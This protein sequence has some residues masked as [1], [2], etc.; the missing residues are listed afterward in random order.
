MKNLRTALLCAIMACSGMAA[1]AQNDNIPINEPDLNKPRLFN[2]LSERI[3]VSQAEMDNLFQINVGT[4][5]QLSLAA[6][7]SVRFEGDLIS[8]STVSQEGVQT[9]IV[10]STNFN[11]ARMT[12]TKRLNADGTVSYIGRILSFQHGDFYELTNQQGQWFLVKK[13]FYDLVNE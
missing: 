9:A 7:A 1:F 3:Q 6:D 10:R 2:N 8:K 11:G 13:N 5:A 4:R 12:I